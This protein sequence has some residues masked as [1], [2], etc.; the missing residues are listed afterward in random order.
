MKAVI[1]LPKCLYIYIIIIINF[2]AGIL[3]YILL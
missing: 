1:L 3:E 2:S